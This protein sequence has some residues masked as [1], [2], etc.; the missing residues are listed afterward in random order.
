[1]CLGSC[2]P[3]LLNHSLT[4]SL[5]PSLPHSLPPSLTHYLTHS[6]TDSLPLSH[7]LT[8]SLPPSLTHSLTTSLTDSLTLSLSHSLTHS[9]TDS[10]PLSLSLTHS[11]THSLTR[12]LTHSSA[13]IVPSSAFR[14]VQNI[15]VW[16]LYQVHTVPHPLL[17]HACHTTQL[18]LHATFKYMGIMVAQRS[19]FILCNFVVLHTHT[20]GSS[21]N[22]VG[23]RMSWPYKRLNDVFN[24]PFS[25]S[26]SYFHSNLLTVSPSSKTGLDAG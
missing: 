16:K 3:S 21:C 9:L 23:V 26:S 13:T 12:S 10:L 4:H 11:L 19:P 5:P 14:C 22:F 6:L 1:M 7:S 20:F 8:H 24:T 25:P 18:L 17:S 2:Y 15:Q